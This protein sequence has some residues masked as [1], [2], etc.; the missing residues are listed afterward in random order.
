[1]SDTTIWLGP[2]LESDFDNPCRY[3]AR[4]YVTDSDGACHTDMAIGRYLVARRDRLI[5]VV[6]NLNG[7]FS[8]FLIDHDCAVVITDRFGTVPIYLASDRGRRTVV[9]DVPWDVIG[10]LATSPRIDE[11]ALI[12]LVHAGYVTG[13]RTLIE[14]VTTAQPAAIT[15][16]EGGQTSVKRYWIYGYK[17]EPMEQP[18]AVAKLKAVLDATISRAG[19]ILEQRGARPVLTLSGGLD[20][21]LLAGLFAGRQNVAPAALSYGSS[22]DPEVV[23][24]AEVSRSL[25]IEHRI[26]DVNRSYFNPQFLDRSVHEVGATTRFT[27]GTGARHLMGS[28]NEC[29]I[30]GHTG[31]FVSGGHLPPHAGLV[32][33]HAQL[34]R[35][36]DLRHFGYPFSDGI[37]SQVLRTDARR[38]F[39]TLAETTAE[40]DMSSD[41]FGL[42]DRWNVENRQRR[43]I[44]MELRAY[45]RSAP[46]ILPFYDYELVDFFARIPHSLRVGQFLYVKTAIERVFTGKMASLATIRRIGKPLAADPSAYRRIQAFAKV[47]PAMRTPLLAAWPLARKLRIGLKKPTVVTQGPDPIRHW[48]RSDPEIG[49]FL[50]DKLRRVSIDLIDTD[51]LLELARQEQAPEEFFHRLITSAITAQEALD[52]ARS[53]WDASM[54]K[55]DTPATPCEHLTQNVAN[56]VRTDEVSSSSSLS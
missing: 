32:R 7:C 41:M 9:S 53:A 5:D 47:P 42:I 30:P 16:F 49:G 8:A 54:G 21:R 28:E 34:L 36:L 19:H 37:L 12:D 2:R 18:D 50:N 23:V 25:G 43:L 24:A 3:W 15:S 22:M 11:A 4:G 56:S 44:L 27:C 48:F 17:P 38:R 29:L 52:Q 33:N 10:R 39:D 46:W 45:E 35:F 40:F 13:A 26:V 6:P 55:H 1:M 31:D 14:G 20:S 51:R